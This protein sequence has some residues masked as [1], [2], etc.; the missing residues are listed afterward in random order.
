MNALVLAAS[1]GGHDL[2]DERIIWSLIASVVL[3]IANGFFVAYEF[4]L[5]AAK[6]SSFEAGAEQGNTTAKASLNAMSDLSAQLAG[7]QLGITMASL[8]LGFVAEPAL[9]ALFERALGTSLSPSLTGTVSFFTALAITVFLHLVVGEMIPKNIAIARP[10]GTVTWLV[11]PYRV[12]NFIFRPFVSLLNAIANV[13]TRLFGVEPTDEIAVSH[14]TAELAAIVSE[15]SLGGGIEADSA[16][17][18]RGA[19][20]FAERPIGEIARPLDEWAT[21]RF[22]AT[23]ANAE[24]VVK[25]SGQTRVPIVAPTL[26]EARLVGYLHAKELLGIAAEDRGQPLPGALTR[27]MAVIREDR[28]LVEALR[29]LRRMKRQLAVVISPDGP[30][31]I[32]SVEEV[33][34][35]LVDDTRLEGTRLE[36]TQL[37]GTQLDGPQV[38]NEKGLLT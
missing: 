10:V 21:V 20:D 9:A 38:E 37:E 19:L 8:G 24:A 34:R 12:Y 11:M 17:L 6:R 3:I 28:P 33:I 22:G 4:A 23:A 18:L 7:S 35:A 15:S 5:L 14:S 36:A 30:I 1:E 13:G 32:V 27:Q 31:G 2:S 25:Q 26:G 16:E 29:I